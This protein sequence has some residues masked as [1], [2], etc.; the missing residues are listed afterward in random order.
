MLISTLLYAVILQVPEPDVPTPPRP[1]LGW[2][3]DVKSAW[4][5]EL[6]EEGNFAAAAQAYEELWKSSRLAPNLYNAALARERL[7]H[8]AAAFAHYKRFLSEQRI[9]AVERSRGEDRLQSLATRTTRMRVIVEPPNVPNIGTLTLRRSDVANWPSVEL[10]QWDVVNGVLELRVEAGIWQLSGRIDGGKLSRVSVVAPSSGEVEARLR[11]EPLQVDFVITVSPPEVL[12]N[13]AHLLLLP[14]KGGEAITIE[15]VRASNRFRVAPGGYRVKA[16]ARGFLP[17]ESFITVTPESNPIVLTFR[18][19]ESLNPSTDEISEPIDLEERARKIVGVTAGTVGLGLIGGGAVFLTS[20]VL[21]LRGAHLYSNYP[22]FDRGSSY[23]IN[24]SALIGAGVGTWVVGATALARNRERAMIA[25]T[26]VGVLLL[27]TAAPLYIKGTK[28][29][30]GISDE[31][32]GYSRVS[33]GL[34]CAYNDFA[35][36]SI[37]GVG[38]GMVVTSAFT[39]ATRALIR[40]RKPSQ[41]RKLKL[42]TGFGPEGISFVGKF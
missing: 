22:L 18:S 24:G 34:G 4:A 17:I 39:L 5:K 38:L 7:G 9:T 21:N 37:Y 12:A 40:N 42:S 14:K 3:E 20:G 23:T 26:G 32:T 33:E 13:G 30:S 31:V 28:C 41:R 15:T 35:A 11:F 27:A 36:T 19:A 10:S 16:E 6:F 29:Y 2:F 25:E 8:Y 1:A